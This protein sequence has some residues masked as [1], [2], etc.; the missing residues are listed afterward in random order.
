MRAG[1]ASAKRVLK[2]GHGGGG[3]Q[4]GVAN[5]NMHRVLRLVL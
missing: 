5:L 3:V 2:V 1:P 4:R